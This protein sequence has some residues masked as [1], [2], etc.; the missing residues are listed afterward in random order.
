MW[1]L[2]GRSQHL[3]MSR[4]MVIR[5]SSL[6]EGQSK[7]RGSLR[8]EVVVVRVA[9]VVLKSH[10]LRSQ[11]RNLQPKQRKQHTADHYQP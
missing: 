11:S 8:V 1:C 3:L 6:I 4:L 10:H 7:L 9:Q 2:K 5:V